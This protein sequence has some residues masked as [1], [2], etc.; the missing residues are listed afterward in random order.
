MYSCVQYSDSC[1]QRST[2]ID[3][4]WKM[5]HFLIQTKSVSLDKLVHQM[6][7]HLSY[8]H[9]NLGHITVAKLVKHS[10]P[11]LVGDVKRTP[12]SV[13]PSYLCLMK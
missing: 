7:T 12:G 4:S 1:A 2:R 11:V 13:K 5:V 6:A 3:K 8:P 10:R 9:A